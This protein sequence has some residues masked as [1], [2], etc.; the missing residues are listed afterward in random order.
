MSS[1]LERGWGIYATEVYLPFSSVYIPFSLLASRFRRISRR[2]RGKPNPQCKPTSL[3]AVSW[4]KL[5]KAHQI[6]L[7][8]AN[9]VNGNVRVSEL[10]VLCQAA[11]NCTAGDVLLEIGT[12]NGRTTLNLSLNAPLDCPIY[13]LDLPPEQETVFDLNPRESIYVQKPEPGLRYKNCAAQLKPFAAR[14][15]QLHGDSAAYDFSSL[16]GKCGFVFVD[17]SHAYDYVVNDTR[18]ARQL[19]K[20]GGMILWHDYGIWNGVTDA[21]EEIE[22]QEHLGLRHVRGTTIVLWRSP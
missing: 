17:G 16:E 19:V 11:R 7:V 4:R 18:I 13:T 8:E 21:L 15:R 1:F 5:L 14:I 20:P 6:R 22:R 12:F 10:G 3:P 2:I 9:S